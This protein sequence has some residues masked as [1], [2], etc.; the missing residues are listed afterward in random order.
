MLAPCGFPGVRRL[1]GTVKR[2]VHRREPMVL[3]N[4][5]MCRF[6]RESALRVLAVKAGFVGK[7]LL[8]PFLSGSVI[9]RKCALFECVQLGKITRV[10]G[11]SSAVCA[12]QIRTMICLTANYRNGFYAAV[13]AVRGGVRTISGRKRQ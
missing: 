9:E 3:A 5:R 10:S 13:S 12:W 7:R 2:F 6:L 1:T 4:S 8:L 11:M